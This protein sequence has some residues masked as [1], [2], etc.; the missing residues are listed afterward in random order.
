MSLQLNV[1]GRAQLSD[2]LRLAGFGGWGKTRYDFRINEEGFTLRGKM[3]GTRH[4]YGVALSGDIPLGSL[5]LTTDAILSRAIEKLGSASFDASYFEESGSNMLIRLGSVDITRLSVP[6]HVPI[7]F[8]SKG[9][10]KEPTRLELSPG[11]LCQDTTQDSSAFDCGYQFGFK[12]QMAPSSRSRLRAQAHYELV[13][14]YA[15]SRFA[16]GLE[17][18]FGSANGLAFGINLERQ[19]SASRQDNRFMLHF[20]VSR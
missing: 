5:T 15:A 6:I 16:L 13:D 7:V 9:N 2:K 14:G 3:D 20:G 10:G 18:R 1:Y 4:L 17:R 12:F 11:L 19:K 8:G